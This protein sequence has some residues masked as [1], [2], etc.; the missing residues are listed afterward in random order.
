M[1]RVVRD[2]GYVKESQFWG[3]VLVTAFAL[4]CI[5]SI[6]LVGIRVHDEGTKKS[7]QYKEAVFTALAGQSTDSY[8]KLGQKTAE[9][10]EIGS[11]LRQQWDKG[12]TSILKDTAWIYG[13]DYLDNERSI[14][15]VRSKNLLILKETPPQVMLMGTHKY[16]RKMLENSWDIQMIQELLSKK[17]TK[18]PNW[19][20]FNPPHLPNWLGWS[21]FLL[22]QLVC[23]FVYLISRYDDGYSSW[24]NRCYPW[25]QLPWR[26]GWPVLG[27]ALLMPGALPL[28]M[29][30]GLVWGGS[31]IP[32]FFSVEQREKR[33]NSNLSINYHVDSHGQ[34]LLIKLQK[35]LGVKDHV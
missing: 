27:M 20:G 23:F 1:V 12:Q 24:W 31:Q 8:K 6:F 21:V 25:Y 11:Y 16:W 30:D 13:V 10:V 5:C 3:P 33:K 18:P 19:K 22:T 32:H 14:E 17:R 26:R 2:R 9:I 28:I 34:D 15:G 29:I 35:K 7:L 4:F